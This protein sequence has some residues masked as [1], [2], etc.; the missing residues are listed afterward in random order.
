M[1][2]ERVV[3][4]ATAGEARTWKRSAEKAGL[5]LSEWLRR[6]AAV[7]A[8]ETALHG[9]PVAAPRRV[10]IA[11]ADLVALAASL[12]LGPDASLADILRAVVAL[13]E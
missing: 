6:S 2:G 4:R 3:L 8:A 11:D 1:K 10:E 12:G 5:T 7:A 13:R 9:V